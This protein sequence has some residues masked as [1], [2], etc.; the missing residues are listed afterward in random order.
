MV[1]GTQRVVR[2]RTEQV[3]QTLTASEQSQTLNTSF[4]ERF[5]GTQRQF[6]GR[7]KRK[8]YT[9][10]KELS[11]HAACT[12]LVVL[13][14]NFGWCVR[15]LREKL[16]RRPPRYS[17]SVH[18]GDPRRPK[19]RPNAALASQAKYR[20]RWICGCALSVA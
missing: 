3:E 11:H 1:E 20:R 15:T 6:N 18:T 4:V 13:W 14:Y 8:A 2:G 9:F 17:T 5:H 12:W 10:S 19:T 16:R 7:K